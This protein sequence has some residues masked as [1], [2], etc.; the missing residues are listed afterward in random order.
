MSTASHRAYEEIRR[1]IFAEEYPAGLRLREDE[2]SAAIGV[3]R[4]PVREALRRLDAE[5]IVV[6]MPNRGAH[7][8]S[9]TDAE[10]EDIFEIRTL[11]ESYAARRA[12]TRMT[13]DDL[14]KLDRLTD[15]MDACLDKL[16]DEEQY[17]RITQLNTEFHQ[18]L[19]LSAGS[20]L[21]VSLTT[22]TVQMPLMHRTF[23]RYSRRALERSFDHHRELVE[24]CRAKDPTWAESIMR[25]HIL[26]ARH[27]FDQAPDAAP[28]PLPQE[29]VSPADA[30]PADV[31]EAT[32][33]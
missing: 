1:R 17:A 5:G 21:L 27:I 11:L 13:D 20:P 2:L 32:H 15:E 3:S 7:V 10:L 33:A 6:N 24:A 30:P 12:A 22:S 14:D 25:S 4:T 8:A 23:L 26:A 9:W 16:P 29:P 18:H 28:V 31:A 19:I